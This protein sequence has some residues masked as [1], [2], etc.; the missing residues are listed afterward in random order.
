LKGVYRVLYKQGDVLGS[1]YR[2]CS[3]IIAES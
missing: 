2:A 1:F 3:N